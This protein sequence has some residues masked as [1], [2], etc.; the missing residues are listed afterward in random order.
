MFAQ[1]D[2]RPLINAGARKADI[3]QSALEA[4]VRQTLGGLACGRPIRG[5]V[6][7]LGGPLE[8]IPALVIAFRHALGL[9]KVTGPKPPDAHLYAAMGACETALDAPAVALSEL[10]K[11]ARSLDGHPDEELVLAP[12]FANAEEHAAFVAA[13][14]ASPLAHR[15][16]DDAEGPL[17][18]GFDAG[19]T[20]MKY[21]LVDANGALLLSDYRAVEGDTFA[22]ARDMMDELL[23]HVEG[24][25]YSRASHFLAHATVT[26]YGEDLLRAGF[27]FDS[28]VVETVAHLR[29]A[30]WIRPDVS[31]LLDIGGQDMKALWVQDGTVVDAVLNE[32]C[33]SGCGAF[34]QSC[35]KSMELTNE[36]FAKCALSAAHPIDLGAKCTVFMTSRVRQAQKAGAEAGDIAAGIAYSIVKNVMERI[37]G[38]GHARSLGP[39]VVVQGGTFKSDAVLRAFELAAGVTASRPESAHLMGALVLRSSRGIGGRS[40]RTS[41]AQPA[42]PAQASC[43]EGSACAR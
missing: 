20:T 27:G 39:A 8:H 26:G 9:N 38:R 29:A 18:L 13:H 4:V 40:S 17:F 33:S 11:R 21:A 2:V 22:T 41:F 16:L 36:E 42:E 24:E 7:F 23:K 25:S 19:S 6:V 28:G 43:S 31:F 34:V 10:E 12:L 15:W 3:A 30:Q 5:N 14:E 37:V 1:T 35:A 32:A